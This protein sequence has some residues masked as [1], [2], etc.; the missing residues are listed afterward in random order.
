MQQRLS[1]K[2]E[3][4]LIALPLQWVEGCRLMQHLQNAGLFIAKHNTLA[5]ELEDEYVGWITFLKD[6]DGRRSTADIL[7]E[8]DISFEE[9]RDFFMLALKEQILSFG[10]EADAIAKAAVEK[11][12]KD[13]LPA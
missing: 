7:G 1:V 6:I 9:I 11:S 3:E 12:A 10:E 4:E 13:K 5:Y 2:T 8:H